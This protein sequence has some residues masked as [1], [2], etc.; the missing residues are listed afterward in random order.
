MLPKRGGGGRGEGNK[1]KKRTKITNETSSRTSGGSGANATTTGAGRFFLH[2]YTAAHTDVN[3]ELIRNE[4]TRGE[5]GGEAFYSRVA[6]KVGTVPAASK[7][8]EPSG[9]SPGPQKYRITDAGDSLRSGAPGHQ[10]VPE[11]FSR[12]RGN[13]FAYDERDARVGEL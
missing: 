6:G 7:Y 10:V 8:G 1:K 3:V 4:A 11:L 9:R 12:N 13:T 2:M 5:G